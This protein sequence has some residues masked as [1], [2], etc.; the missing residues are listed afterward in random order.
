[1]R[2][3]ATWFLAGLMALSGA[4][5]ALDCDSGGPARASDMSFNE[6]LAI[7]AVELTAIRGTGYSTGLAL[8]GQVENQTQE[9]LIIEV[10]LAEPIVFRNT[11]VGQNMLA[12]QIL[13]SGGRYFQ[14]D[15]R[16]LIHVEPRASIDVELM[17]YCIDFRKDNPTQTETLAIAPTPANLSRVARQI[18]DYEQQHPT[19]D[20]G[21]GAQLALW[22]SQGITLSEISGKFD[23]TFEDVVHMETILS[24]DVP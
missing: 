5:I 15:Q 21:V 11:G 12:T 7:G 17:A 3:F 20:A 14:E 10:N 19:G 13:F 8:Q 18:A 4:L 2:T 1:M 6:A 23:Y 9:R 24:M 22:T 16:A